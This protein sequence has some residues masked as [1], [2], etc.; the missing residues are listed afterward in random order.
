MSKMKVRLL[1]IAVSMQVLS[2]LSAQQFENR[3]ISE[4]FPTITETTN[5]RFSTNVPQPK[6]GGGF[7][8][9]ITGY[10]INVQ[11]YDSILINLN[12]NIFQPVGDTLSRR[13]VVI[14][15]FGGGFVAGSKDHWS[16]RLLA[17][18][19]AKRGFVTAVID[20]RLGMNIFNKELSKRAVYRGVQDGRSAVR[21]FKADAAGANIYKIDSSQIYIGGH[22]AGAFVATHNA[23]LDTEAKRPLSTYQT[24]Q[25]CGFLCTPKICKDQQCL[26]CVGDNKSF[27]G[28]AR[29]VFSLAGAIGD[30]LYMESISNPVL[31]MFHSTDDAT[32]PFNK[33]VPFS[34]I[35]S[36]VI[37][38]DLPEVFGSNLMHTRATNL[39][40]V[41]TFKAYTNR[42]HDVHELSATE[43]HNDIVPTIA[44][45]FNQHLLKPPTHPVLGKK[46][47]CKSALTSTYTTQS[48]LAA[49]YKW[50]VT[51]GAIA[52]AATPANVINIVWDTTATLHKIKLTPYSKWESAGDSTVLDIQIADQFSNTWTQTSGNWHD[53]SAW[54]LNQV[55]ESCH[56]VVFPDKSIPT[57]ILHSN[58]LSEIKSLTTGQNVNITLIGGAQIRVRK[59]G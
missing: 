33:G 57:N 43:L 19:L 5:V 10:P 8:E 3:Y 54:L 25:S 22:S 13:P 46:Y 26:D 4:V 9:S 31:S 6:P 58:S 12:M 17:Q 15:C 56:N 21:F 39:S 40:L 34:S 48:N 55:P 50:E 42:G 18:S 53:Q 28:K 45:W 59:E 47:I 27:N 20:Y 7:Y 14:I 52:M 49:L 41:D 24:T 32:V 11:E 30:T 38:F 16:M 51:G 36:L 29:A 35:S 2:Y 37:G 23:Y 1:F 44:H